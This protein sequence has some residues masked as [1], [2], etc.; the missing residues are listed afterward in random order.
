[1]CDVYAVL[2]LWSISMK[3]T[4]SDDEFFLTEKKI[5]EQKTTV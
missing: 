2:H 1:M 3:Q 5:H 4:H